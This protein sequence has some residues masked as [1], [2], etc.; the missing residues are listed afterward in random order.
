[1]RHAE[2]PSSVRTLGVF[3]IE[4]VVAMALGAHS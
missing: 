3:R 2:A 1:M 4:G